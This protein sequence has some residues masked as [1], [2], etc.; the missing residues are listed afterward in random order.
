MS[1]TK[2]FK[3]PTGS[4]VDGSRFVRAWHAYFEGIEDT[5]GR[6]AAYVDPSTAT[7]QQIA[8]AMIDAKLM[9]SS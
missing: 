3:M 6:V 4:P 2:L 7:A 9:K 8:Q 5:S 1:T